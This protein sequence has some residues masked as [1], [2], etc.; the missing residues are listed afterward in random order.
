MRKSRRKKKNIRTYIGITISLSAVLLP[1]L[2]ACVCLTVKQ[3]EKQTDRQIA[4]DELLLTYMNRIPEQ[5]YGQ[6]YEMTDLPD[7]GQIQKQDFIKRNKAI[8]QGMEI[9]NMKTKILSYQEEEQIVRYETSFD[10]PAGNIC[11]ENEAF[12]VKTEKGY[13]LAWNDA[14]IYPQLR[15][16]DKIR[17]TVQQAQRG[18][19]LDRNGS[20]LAGPGTASV[21]GIVPGKLENRDHAVSQIADL[22][23]IK[24]EQIEKKLSAGWVR[25]DSFV[26]IKT[27]RKVEETD[28]MA[29]EPDEEVLKE[30]QRQQRLLEIAGVMISDTQ[31]RSYPLGEAASHLAGYVQSVTAEDLEKHAGEGYTANSVIGRSGAEG[32]FEQE[33][34]GKNGCRIYIVDADGKETEE[35]ACKKAEHGRNIRLTIDAG[36]QKDLYEQFQEDKGCSVAMHPYTGEVLALVSTPSYDNNDFILGLSDEQW[37]TLNEDVNQPMFNRFRQVWCPGSSFKPITAAIGLDTGAVDPYE[38]YGNVGLSW[39]KDASWG[40][41]YVT[42]LHAYEPV[43]MENALIYS[44]NIYFAKAALKIGAGQLKTSLLNL[45]FTQRIPF[46]IAMSKSRYSNTENI[47]T[48]IQLADSGYGQGQMLINPLHLAGIY[49][50]FCNEGNMI[51]PYLVWREDTRPQ[52]WIKNAFS[53]ETASLV[54]SGMQKVIS[55]VHGTGYKAY[56]DDVVLAGKTGTAE[57]KAAK[58]DTSGTELGWFVVLTAEKTVDRPVLIV[59]MTED[60]K[61]RGGSGYV[62]EKQKQVLDH[63]FST[64]GS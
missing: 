6:M 47:E 27:L 14:C 48:E 39:Q 45:G 63:W 9:Q 33:L 52:Y 19:I 20:V 56:R 29:Q 35:L 49:T 3:K 17:V 5:K 40:A 30:Q 12:F 38:D 28:L 22:L 4:P 57:I 26:P 32:L 34:K 10:T 53:K 37:K 21:A 62:V 18:K 43:V 54:C 36:L 60:V 64:A 23:E 13:R 51:K 42:T 8:Y 31:I 11:F 58:E 16:D 59:T 7:S 50:A 24:T 61:G 55:D 2:A 44:D 41:Y 25:D 15:A 1:I 46:E